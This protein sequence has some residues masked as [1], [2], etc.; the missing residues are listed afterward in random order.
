MIPAWAARERTFFRSTMQALDGKQVYV[1][2]AY[3][4]QSANT[5]RDYV[6]YLGKREPTNGAYAYIVHLATRNVEFVGCG[7]VKFVVL[8]NQRRGL[9]PDSIIYEEG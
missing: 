3:E 9:R 4:R 8:S 7:S 6:E 1:A 2:S 5:F